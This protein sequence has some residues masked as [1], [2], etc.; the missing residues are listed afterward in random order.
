MNNTTFEERI[1]SPS[2]RVLLQEIVFVTFFLL[3]FHENLF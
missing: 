3:E 2:T 1:N